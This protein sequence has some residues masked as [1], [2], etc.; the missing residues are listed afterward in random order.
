MTRG[1]R[2][3]RRQTR[4]INDTTVYKKTK[5]VQTTA[6]IKRSIW[7]ERGGGRCR[8]QTPPSPREKE[9]RCEHFCRVGS[10]FHQSKVWFVLFSW[11]AWSK[12]YAFFAVFFLR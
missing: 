3:R 2:R 5:R 4:I 7:R 1:R 11:K 8:R 6:R 10:F 12:K 9:E